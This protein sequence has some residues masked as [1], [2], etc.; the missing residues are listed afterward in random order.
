MSS[1][2][3]SALVAVLTT[4]LVE[5]LAKPRLEARKER[6]LDEA[7]GRRA[8]LTKLR[9]TAFLFKRLHESMH[10]DSPMQAF[11]D[12]D[13]IRDRIRSTIDPTVEVAM[14]GDFGL[15][16]SEHTSLMAYVAMLEF[17]R[18]EPID[19]EQNSDMVVD[20]LDLATKALDTPSWRFLANRRIRRQAQ[21]LA[22]FAEVEIP[23]FSP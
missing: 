16:S 10:Q 3:A 6:I 23:R 5:Y 21:S 14:G 4:L 13:V 8:V 7:R 22:S 17:W 9:L 15:S 2:F 12:P 1:L 19:F 18:D 20:C 11:E